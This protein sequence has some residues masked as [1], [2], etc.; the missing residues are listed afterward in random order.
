MSHNEWK[1]I[2]NKRELESVKRENSQVCA[3][4]RETVWEKQCERA[5]KSLRFESLRAWKREKEKVQK[6]ERWGM[7][8]VNENS[9]NLRNNNY[10]YDKTK[11]RNAS[12][13]G[14]VTITY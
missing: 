1:Q 6:R 13:N 7:K 11:K 14:G 9:H 8:W 2:A 3:F 10:Y 12:H 4:A 5:L